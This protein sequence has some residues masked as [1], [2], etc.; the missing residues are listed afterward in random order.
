MKVTVI[1]TSYNHEKFLR[2]SIESVLNQ[3]YQNFELIIVD[4]YSTDNSWDIIQTYEKKYDKIIAIH[5][6]HNWGTGIVVDVV[7]NYASGDYIAIQHSDDVWEPT[8]LQQQIDM[9]RRIPDCVAVFTNACAIDDAGKTYSKKDGFYYELFHVKNRTRHEW[10]NYFFYHGNC[11]CH[12]SILVK[13]S[14]YECDGFF[15]KGLRQIPDFVKWIQI[16]KKHEIYVLDEPLVKFRVHDAG[17]NSSGMRAD[18]QIRS[19]IE[20]FLMLNEYSDIKDKNE[21]LKIFPEAEKYCGGEIFVPEYAFGRLCIEE[22]MPPYTRLYGVQLLYKALNCPE[23]EMAMRV[24]YGYTMRKFM[25]DNGKIDIFSIL[26]DHFEQYRS[27]YFDFGDGWVADRAILEKFTFENSMSYHMVTEID[28]ALAS[29]IVRLRFDP[30][31]G[32]MIKNKI[33][34]V[35][36]DGHEVLCYPDNATIKD[37][38]FDVFIDLDPRYVVECVNNHKEVGKVQLSIAGEMI[39]LSSDDIHLYEQ[40]LITAY[41]E[42]IG[43]F[44]NQNTALKQDILLLQT[45]YIELQKQNEKLQID[46]ET[47]VKQKDE[48][49]KKVIAFQNTFWYKLY[50]ISRKIKGSIW[51]K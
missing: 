15:R 37:N 44:Q 14:V 20:L 27:I 34:D 51:K 41:Q 6:D 7:E 42:H 31:E 9:I 35:R 26:P 17:K 4:D 38:E 12:P 1:L 45:Q 33:I 25:D 10:L 48:L 47:I 2:E 22:G 50:F 36:M 43:E 5:H 19:T 16:C 11:L 30:L 21:F 40:R 28:M 29:K 32:V 8:K 49:H 18:T 24:Q 39:R 13:K 46:N 23:K 3:T